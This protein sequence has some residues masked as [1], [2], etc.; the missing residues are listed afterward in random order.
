MS[1][2][3][4]DLEARLHNIRFLLTDV[5][6]VLTDGSL[7]YDHAGNESSFSIEAASR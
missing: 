6:G 5:D 4:A 1:A 2:I 3:D 7:Y